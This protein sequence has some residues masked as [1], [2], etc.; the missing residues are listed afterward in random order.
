MLHDFNNYDDSL[1]DSHRN[2]NRR[3]HDARLHDER[4]AHCELEPRRV[5]SC[6]GT[7]DRRIGF[8]I[9]RR[10]SW[11]RRGV[12]G[13]ALLAAAIF[14]LWRRK[15]RQSAAGSPESTATTVATGGGS[16][17]WAYEEQNAKF[18][19]G[20]SELAAPGP[21]FE[22]ESTAHQ[23]YE[24]DAS[25]QAS[26]ELDSANTSTRPTQREDAKFR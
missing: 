13:G 5:H 14:F 6:H 12:A 25:G 24:L 23:A 8:H 26:H 17:G 18:G 4:C 11:C 15:R 7:R 1:D 21:R 9:Y 2:W 10:H 22:M 16:S 19:H 20:H 3:R